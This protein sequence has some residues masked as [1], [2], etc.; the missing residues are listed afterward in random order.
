[1]AET[2]FAHNEGN[3]YFIT[4]VVRQLAERGERPKKESVALRVDG[5]SSTLLS[6]RELVDKRH[7]VMQAGLLDLLHPRPIRV[8]DGKV[9]AGNFVGAQG[10]Y[11]RSSAALRRAE[12]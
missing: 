7:A 3:P 8:S 6:Q 10:R 4:E 1:M 2:I 9:C 5:R 12:A 11:R